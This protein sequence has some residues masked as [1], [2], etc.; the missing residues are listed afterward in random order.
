[1]FCQPS[2]LSLISLG[3]FFVRTQ[4][5]ASAPAQFTFNDFEKLGE[6]ILKFFF[7]KII[8]FSKV[9]YFTIK[10]KILQKFLKI[11]SVRDR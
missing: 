11:D 9:I 3:S 1:M 6:K 7:F 10:I 4:H 2:L 5:V 8:F